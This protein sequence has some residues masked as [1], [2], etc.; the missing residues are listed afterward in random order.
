MGRSF[1][2]IR[3]GSC[4]ISKKPH[5]LFLCRFS[6]GELALGLS[7]KLMEKKR[8]LEDFRGDNISPSQETKCW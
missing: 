7:P 8:F 3:K 5:I 1:P 2:P 6:E 4:A